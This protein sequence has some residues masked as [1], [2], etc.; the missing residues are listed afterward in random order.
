MSTTPRLIL[1]AIVATIMVTASAASGQPAAPTTGGPEYTLDR[2]RGLVGSFD[3]FGGQLNQHLYAKISGPPPRLADVE[4]KVIALEPQLVRIFFNTSAWEN[5]DRL[6][7]FVR[8]VRLADR[9]N[10]EINVTW[11]GST[12]AF[13]MRNMDRFAELLSSLARRRL[14]RA[15]VGDDVQRTEHNAANA[16][17]VRAGL[18]T[19]PTGAESPG[20]A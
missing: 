16:A 18:P 14:D 19:P 1:V 7:S 13:A 9:A 10:A 11:Q 17:G 6:D 3:G 4:A 5:Q 12:F 8:T 2:S 15:P 20:H